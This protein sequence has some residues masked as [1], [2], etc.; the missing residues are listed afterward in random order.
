VPNNANGGQIGVR[1]FAELG[2]H[3]GGQNSV[4]ADAAISS[5]RIVETSVKIKAVQGL[6]FR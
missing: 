4:E 2:S 5:E 1:T 3:R 6:G